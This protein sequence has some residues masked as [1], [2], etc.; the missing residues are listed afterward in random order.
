M[1]SSDGDLPETGRW[2]VR[3]CLMVILM[4]DFDGDFV[5][6]ICD[7]AILGGL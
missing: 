1:G 5:V 4:G 6:G 3:Q 2:A 7:I